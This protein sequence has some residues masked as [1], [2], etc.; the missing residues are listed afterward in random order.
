MVNTVALIVCALFFGGVMERAKML[1]AVAIKILSLAKST[2]S[3]I[4][5]TVGTAVATNVLAGDQYLSIV[6]P[7]RIFKDAYAERDL[8]PVTLSR[9]LED[10]GTLTSPLVPWN[11]CGAYMIATLGV[12]PWVYVPYCFLNLI[13]PL[14]SII[15]GYTGITIRHLNSKN[16]KKVNIRRV[17]TTLLHSLGR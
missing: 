7:G 11:S 15:Y 3:L 12:A 6:L 10:S 8:H 2:G 16:E 9:V 13:N 1:Q 5:A 14:V 4:L 17:A